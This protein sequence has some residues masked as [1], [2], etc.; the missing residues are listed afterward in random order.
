MSQTT[1]KPQT[2]AELVNKIYEDNYSHFEFE[3]NMGGDSCDCYLHKTMNT[4]VE[5]WGK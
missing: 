2:I 1:H 5:Y 3:E 4:I